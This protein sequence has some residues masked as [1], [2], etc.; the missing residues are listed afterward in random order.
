MNVSATKHTLIA[1]NS[2]KETEHTMH[3][4]A[5]RNSVVEMS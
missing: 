3:S 4:L 1:W 5:A 2:V